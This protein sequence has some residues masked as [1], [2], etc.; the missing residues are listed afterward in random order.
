MNTSL[1]L[2]MTNTS[3]PGLITG[4]TFFYKHFAAPQL[5]KKE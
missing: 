1:I 5:E 2:T 4:L 3:P